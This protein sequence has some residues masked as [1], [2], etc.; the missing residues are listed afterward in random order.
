MDFEWLV[1]IM[2][3]TGKGRGGKFSS[4]GCIIS[5]TLSPRGNCFKP[6]SVLHSKSYTIVKK[7][8]IEKIK[9]ESSPLTAICHIDLLQVIAS[10]IH[11]VVSPGQ[12]YRS[13]LVKSPNTVVA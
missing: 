4:P 6:L 9:E 1:L 5:T 13:F 3:S 12:P 11:T 8:I 2:V 7:I 10:S